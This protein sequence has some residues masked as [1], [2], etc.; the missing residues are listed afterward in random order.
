MV[1]PARL[2]LST[3]LQK[4]SPEDTDGRTKQTSHKQKVQIVQFKINN[5]FFQNWI[6]EI[7]DFY[8]FPWVICLTQ[9]II[10]TG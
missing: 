7:M 4:R 3:L 8:N 10:V 5:F 1:S 9:S 6:Q 2:S